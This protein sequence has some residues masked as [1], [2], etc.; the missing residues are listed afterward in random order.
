METNPKIRN[1]RNESLNDEPAKFP[2]SK[3][4]KLKHPKRKDR[5]AQSQNQPMGKGGKKAI[6][7][8]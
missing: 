6:C 7:S 4:E 5:L 3:M 2:F 8:Y 1:I